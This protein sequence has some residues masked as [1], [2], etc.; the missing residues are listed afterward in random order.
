MDRALVPSSMGLQ[1][2][3]KANVGEGRSSGFEVSLDYNHYFSNGMWLTGR[4][5]F[6]YATSQYDVYEEP[7][8]SDMPWRS[9]VGRSTSQVW[10]YVAERL[11]VD[12][13]DVANSPKQN[14][15]GN[16]PTMGGDIKYKDI[17]GDGQITELDQVPIGFP[18]VPW[19]STVS[20]CHVDGKASM[21][22]CFSKGQHA[23][24][25]GLIRT[26]PHRLFT[27]NVPYYKPMPMI[28]GLK[29]TVTSTHYGRVFPKT[30]Y[31]TISK[32]ALGLCV[33]VRSSA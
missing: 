14:F 10:G 4:G 23:L 19:R 26:R 7:D 6:T 25:F 13:Y 15:G 16:L 30:T 20:D 27:S 24:H 29:T 28:I 18:T 22:H 2:N 31:R 8:Y 3:P 1:A 12:E 32:P 17:N 11:F 5:N 33:T 21:L 9:H